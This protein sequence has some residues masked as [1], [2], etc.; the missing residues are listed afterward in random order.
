MKGNLLTLEVKFQL[1]TNQTSDRPL[2]IGIPV[3]NAFFNW[4]PIC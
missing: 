4:V 1:D 3:V 2:L